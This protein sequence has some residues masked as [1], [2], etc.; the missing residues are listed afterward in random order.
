MKVG[1]F[2]ADRSEDIWNKL[3]QREPAF[4]KHNIPVDFGGTWRIVVGA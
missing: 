1:T 2:A 3:Q 4:V